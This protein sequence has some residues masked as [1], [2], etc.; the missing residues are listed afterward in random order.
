[1]FPL[2][3]ME[4]TFTIQVS[5]NH[6]TRD[7]MSETVIENVEQAPVKKKW[8]IKIVLFPL[9]FFGI[10]IWT[11][12]SFEDAL[13]IS[14]WGFPFYWF[15]KK[16]H[17]SDGVPMNHSMESRS[18]F[19]NRNSSNN[20]S[21]LCFSDNSLQNSDSSPISLNE[22]FQNNPSFDSS[23]QSSGI[24]TANYGTPGYDMSGTYTG[25]STAIGGISN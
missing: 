23:F 7:V 17:N 25:S 6:E 12:F 9:M 22:S 21:S 11:D 5:Q 20:D 18:S 19:L 13:I 4:Q 24:Q 16:A 3:R 1:M 15:W 14:I 10:A 8:D 2:Q